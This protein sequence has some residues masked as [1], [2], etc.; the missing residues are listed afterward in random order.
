MD[1][2]VFNEWV[3][4]V[5]AAIKEIKGDSEMKETEP[6]EWHEQ[7]TDPTPPMFYL[8]SN[9]EGRYAEISHLGGAR[10]YR[11]AIFDPYEPMVKTDNLRGLIASLQS[12]LALA[13]EHFGEDWGKD[14]G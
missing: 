12:I 13:E 2:S 1:E 3:A 8:V 11:T 7:P 4:E 6:R 5:R 10:V 9:D 14:D